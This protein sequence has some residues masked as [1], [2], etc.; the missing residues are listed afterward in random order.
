MDKIR[1]YFLSRI[2][3]NVL[4]PDTYE[5]YFGIEV[6]RLIIFSAVFLLVVVISTI[7]FFVLSYTPMKAFLPE[8]I[9]I[10][11]KE[12][13]IEQQL[14]LDSLSKQ[15][16]LSQ[17]Y[18]EDLRAI[19]S[20]RG[21]RLDVMPDSIPKVEKTQNLIDPKTSEAEQALM[22]KIQQDLNK[23]TSVAQKENNLYGLF[24]YAPVKGIMSQVMSSEHPAVDIVTNQNEPV[25]SV[26]DGRVIFSEF[27][28]TSGYTVIIYHNGQFISVYKHLQSTSKKAGERVKVGEVIGAVGNTGVYSTGPHLHFELISEGRYVNPSDYI[29]FK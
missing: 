29:S 23:T 26:L 19:L 3:I 5:P 4:S 12:M 13:L 21:S 20:G 7:T 15:V 2:K 1:K 10:A 9:K 22:E 25:K 6:S 27:S 24:F 8:S 11:D 14:R 18:A 17:Q 16:Q 28:K